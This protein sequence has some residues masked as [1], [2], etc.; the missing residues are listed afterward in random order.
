MQVRNLT[1]GETC[2]FELLYYLCGL[3][4]GVFVATPCFKDIKK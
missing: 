3:Q 4:F 2:S 1:S